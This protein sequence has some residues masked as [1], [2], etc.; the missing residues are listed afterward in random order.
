MVIDGKLPPMSVI[1]GGVFH[2]FR[3]LIL[4]VENA[5]V[6]FL[7]CCELEPNPRAANGNQFVDKNKSKHVVVKFFNF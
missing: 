5:R 2:I 6:V 7:V 1:S 4:N 3:Y